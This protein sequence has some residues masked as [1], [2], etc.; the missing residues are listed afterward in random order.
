MP[1]KHTKL[2]ND[3]TKDNG[4]DSTRLVPW[5]SNQRLPEYREGEAS[6]SFYDNITDLLRE[7]SDAQFGIVSTLSASGEW[8]RDAT[9]ATPLKDRVADGRSLHDSPRILGNN[10][11]LR[12]LSRLRAID[13][14][15]SKKYPDDNAL[16]ERIKGSF[17]A[18][19]QAML[20]KA[21]GTDSYEKKLKE[22]E[23]LE[24][25]FNTGL[26]EVLHE[27]G[28]AKGCK[29][30]A[31]AEKL[32]AHYRN[33]SSLL[34]P[35]RTLVTL[36]YD[37][38]AK[39]F[40]RETQYP[41]TKKSNAQKLAIEELRGIGSTAKK[42]AHTVRNAA[43][44]EADSLFVDLM[45]MD[46][47]ALPAQT[48]KTHLAG[49]KNAFIVKNEL[50]RVPE[51]ADPE[52]FLLFNDEASAEDTLWL[53]RSATPVYT[54]PGETE[55]RIQQHTRE[56]LEQIRRAAGERMGL[57]IYHY[58]SIH[59][60]TLNTVSPTEDQSVMVRHIYEATR[61]KKPVPGSEGLRDDV[62]Y[63]P[64]NLDGT[65]RFLDI[66]PAL[67]REMHTST[68]KAPRGSAPFQ[69]ATRL[70][71][72][73]R[74]MLAA[75]RPDRLSMVQCASGQDRT[76][77]AVEK[78]VQ[79]WLKGRY[80]SLPKDHIVE[81]RAMGGNAAEIASHHIP[82]SP[83][84]KSL[85]IANNQ[86][87][88]RRPTFSEPAMREFYRK[89]ADMNKE[90]KVGD[91]WFLQSTPESRAAYSRE[92]SKLTQELG[93]LSTVLSDP[94]TR[95]PAGLMDIISGTEQ[96][97]G[98][99]EIAQSL[100]KAITTAED[101]A[102]VTNVVHHTRQVLLKMM[103]AVPEGTAFIKD[104]HPISDDQSILQNEAKEFENRTH[105]LWKRLGEILTL[106]LHSIASL[107]GQGQQLG[108]KIEQ[109]RHERS[110]AEKM[111]LFK[112]QVSPPSPGSNDD[113]EGDPL[114]KK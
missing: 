24:T 22:I 104:D 80:D 39:V 59:V 47:R 54:G 28:L 58:P 16:R 75:A 15:L 90:N 11:L 107:F 85:S 1:S 112:S 94:S 101:L 87:G 73:T 86:L 41:V 6:V 32:L 64:T 50:I 44:Q 76:G 40:H 17:I 77:T 93:F 43:M 91:V 89:S 56:N 18:L 70:D 103:T 30:A 13:Y 95:L 7:V 27:A 92:Y 66:A 108:K 4:L 57:G 78:T 52:A 20:S 9:D 14:A 10:A 79:K 113:S 67:Q 25:E 5:L 106:A 96:Q 114:L 35:A 37:E 72:V 8:V 19:T 98:M 51:G 100:G 111:K 29:T 105:P 99:L 61:G 26:V 12:C 21:E 102:K 62:S 88:Q 65:F 36:T 3:L 2:F 97:S 81:A 109:M 55:K 45:L 46:D 33:L 23:R 110:L 63:M 31:D 60:I 68:K 38:K 49:A 74:V 82:G 42:T 84:M 71:S 48:R 53:A 69:K 34:V 83:G